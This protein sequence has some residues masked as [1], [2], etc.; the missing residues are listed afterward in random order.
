MQE[1]LTIVHKTQK[2]GLHAEHLDCTYK[3]TH[4]VCTHIHAHS[5]LMRVVTGLSDP[6][7]AVRSPRGFRNGIQA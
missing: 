5:I 4:I 1:D 7:T 6:L 2:I 3:H